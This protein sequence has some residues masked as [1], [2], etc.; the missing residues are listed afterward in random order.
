MF[1]GVVAACS[2]WPVADYEAYAHSDGGYE[3][4]YASHAV[5]HAA[6]ISSQN[7][8]RHDGPS[9]GYTA[10]E[11]EYGHGH[12]DHYY[13]EYVSKPSFLLTFS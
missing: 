7:V 2:C 1:L 4:E 5:G 10:P 13:D 6:A 8:V 12:A 11:H 3:P 9:H